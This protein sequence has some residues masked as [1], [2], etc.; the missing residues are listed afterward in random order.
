MVRVIASAAGKKSP[1]GSARVWTKS[2]QALEAAQELAVRLELAQLV[3][4]AAQTLC[5]RHPELYVKG[6]DYRAIAA[7]VLGVARS[8]LGNWMG[9]SEHHGIPVTYAARLI[10]R[11]EECG[12]DAVAAEIRAKIMSTITGTLVDKGGK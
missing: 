1:Q 3:E 9:S 2:E 12:A 6:M 8:T 5:S 11:L 7:Q 10:K 4:Q